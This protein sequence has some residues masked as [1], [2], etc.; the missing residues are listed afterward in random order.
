[1]LLQEHARTGRIRWRAFLVRRMQRLFPAACVMVCAVAAASWLLDPAAARRSLADVPAAL[2]FSSNWWQLA[3]QQ[4]YFEAQGRP[5]LLQ[6]LW[7]LAI[8]E[9]FYLCWPALM[10]AVLARWRPRLVCAVAL[11]LACASAGW[12]AL[13]Y[14]VH[15]DA[16]TRNRIYLGSDTHAMGLLVGAALGCGAARLGTL[17]P[18]RGSYAAHARSLAGIAAI[19]ALGWMGWT[20]ND[21]TPALYLGGFVAVPVLT[22][23]VIATSVDSYSPVAWLL[24]RPLLQWCG[25]RSYSLYLWHWPV[26]AWLRHPAAEAQRSLPWTLAALALSAAVAEVSY[27]LL[28]RRQVATRSATPPMAW[29]GTLACAVMLALLVATGD[30]LESA[31][32]PAPTTMAGKVPPTVLLAS[33]QP[34][35]VPAQPVGAPA[36]LPA[37]GNLQEEAAPA[38]PV[39]SHR[40]ITV[41]GDSVMLGAKPYLSHALGADVDAVVGRQFHEG[42]QVVSRLR[43]RQALGQVVVLHLGTN[44]YIVE[45]HARE[46][47][48]NLRDC[49]R[50]VVV[51]VRAERRWTASNNAILQRLVA[52]TSNATLLDWNAA[53]RDHPEWFVKDGI[54]LTGIGIAALTR[55]VAQSTGAVLPRGYAALARRPAGG[56]LRTGPTPM[57]IPAAAAAAA[58]SDAL[59]VP[60]ANGE[61]A[62]EPGPGPAAA[63]G[64]P[65]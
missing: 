9:Q 41:I 54:H 26:F 29:S 11:L 20:W 8:E 44:G 62:P 5:P 15:D 14:L 37:I 45:A 16:G 1:L 39:P 47:M 7:S 52:Q 30:S 35:A 65:L 32:P 6:H 43:A 21:A 55:E 56:M 23:L 59:V 22:A 18:P 46:L 36:V 48:R 57:P 58:S 4:S 64:N 33:T 3:S 31:H 12:M 61:G 28:E 25:T 27:A 2:T 10:I 60:A 49:E 38:R 17:T 63:Q 24:R 42:L 51:D 50:V 13:L 34:T 53:S 19:V 40:D